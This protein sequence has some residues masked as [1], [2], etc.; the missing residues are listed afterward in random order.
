MLIY[1]SSLFV[2]CILKQKYE[3]RNPIS[4]Y[5]KFSLNLMEL[6][7]RKELQPWGGKC[8]PLPLLAYPSLII[9]SQ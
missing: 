8:N 7:S 1:T 6:T 5:T 2:F 4:A 9:M 3:Q